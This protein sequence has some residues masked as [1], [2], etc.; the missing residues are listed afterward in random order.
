MQL[1]NEIGWKRK[2]PTGIRRQVLEDTMKPGDGQS[3]YCVYGLESLGSGGISE[4][5][6]APQTSG[7]VFGGVLREEGRGHHIPPVATSL[8][9]SEQTRICG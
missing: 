3:A 6:A 9:T 4:L 5:P 2:R 7:V 1:I 8:V